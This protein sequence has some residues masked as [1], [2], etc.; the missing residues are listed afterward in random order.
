MKR[1]DFTAALNLLLEH[2]VIQP[3]TQGQYIYCVEL[4]RQWVATQS[5]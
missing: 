5:N 2:D 1:C 3:N 4:M